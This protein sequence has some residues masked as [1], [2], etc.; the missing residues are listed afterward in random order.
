MPGICAGRGRCGRLALRG[1]P[2]RA[3]PRHGSGE[4]A[5]GAHATLSRSSPWL[6]TV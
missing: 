4:A 6:C 5:A 1:R 2:G 3:G